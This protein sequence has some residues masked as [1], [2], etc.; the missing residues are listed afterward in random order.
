M[1]WRNYYSNDLIAVAGG[2]RMKC[3]CWR[4]RYGKE[5]NSRRKRASNWTPRAI[6]VSRPNLQTE[7][8]TFA[9]IV[10]SAVVPG[11]AAKSPFAQIRSVP[12]I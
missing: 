5:V 8:A 3:R 9:I 1:F 4:T 2:S 7:L 10:T 6:S 12:I 11:A